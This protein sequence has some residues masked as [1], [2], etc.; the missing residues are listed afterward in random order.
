MK[1][2]GSKFQAQGMVW[3]NRAL[4]LW[5]VAWSKIEEEM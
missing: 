4:P 1:G 2:E 3:L 5:E